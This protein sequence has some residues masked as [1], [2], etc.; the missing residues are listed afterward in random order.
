M[1]LEPIHNKSEPPLG[2]YGMTDFVNDGTGI[3]HFKWDIICSH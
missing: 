1:C 2:K 3:P